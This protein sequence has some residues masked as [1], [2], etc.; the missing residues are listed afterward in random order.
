[1]EVVNMILKITLV[2][3][4]GNMYSYIEKELKKIGVYNIE[5]VDKYSHEKEKKDV[6]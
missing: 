1:M 6:V 5:I 4:V 3:S 2:D